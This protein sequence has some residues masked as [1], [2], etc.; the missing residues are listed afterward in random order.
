MINMTIMTRMM[1]RKIE[2][3][4]NAFKITLPNCNYKIDGSAEGSAELDYETRIVE[5]IKERGFAV[6]SDI[7]TLLGVSQSTAS[8]ILRKMINERLIYPEGR[9]KTTRY[10][11]K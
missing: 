6:R 11:R 10:K 9:G 8:R 2:A 1:T 4:N 7:D 3:T 5:F